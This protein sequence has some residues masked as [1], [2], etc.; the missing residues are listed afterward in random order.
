MQHGLCLASSDTTFESSLKW[1]AEALRVSRTSCPSWIGVRVT[2]S[3]G[4]LCPL[5][6]QNIGG[7][8]TMI[9]H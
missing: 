5:A 4:A 6:D 2:Q 8:V 9:R 7:P 3:C 1:I